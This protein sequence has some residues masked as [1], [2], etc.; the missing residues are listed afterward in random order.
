MTYAIKLEQF[1]GP[2]DLLLQLVESKELDISTV[3]L[4]TVTEQ[5]LDYLG[6]IEERFPEELADFLVVATKLLL[7]KSR[8]LLPDL[9]VDDDDEETLAAQLRIYKDYL[10]ASHSL[11]AMIA[12]RRFLYG[13]PTGSLKI[14]P[15]FSPPPGLAA[16]ELRE[17]FREVLVGIEVFISLP[18]ERLRRTVSLQERITDLQALIQENL[19]VSFK[20]ILAKAESRSE[21]IVT[22]L[23]LLELV[24]RRIVHVRQHEH[25][26]DIAIERAHH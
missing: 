9:P 15:V 25:F 7:L 17:V 21:V 10:D 1:E 19:T 11:E 23:A 14:E 18:E 20:N 2:L 3:S 13:R 26:G 6:T 4:A 8:L 16:S 12:K 24:K 5:Y 22:F